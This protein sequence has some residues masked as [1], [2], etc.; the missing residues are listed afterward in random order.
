MEN[1]DS[2]IKISSWRLLVSLAI[3]IGLVFLVAT[4]SGRAEELWSTIV[5]AKWRWFLVAFLLQVATYVCDGSKW[6]ISIKYAGFNLKIRSLAKMAVEQLS[7]NQF[8]PSVGM[9]G[10]AI[11]ATEM[12][13]LG[14]PLRVVIRAIAIDIISLLSSYAVITVITL[15]FI[16]LSGLGNFYLM[17]ILVAFFLFISLCTV[18]FWQFLH[19]HREWKFLNFVRRFKAVSKVLDMMSQI[20]QEEIIP[21]QL[22]LNSTILRLIIFIL[23]GLTLYVLMLSIGHPAGLL[24]T[25]I[26]H[27]AGSIGGVMSFLPGGIGGFEAACTLILVL[28]GVPIEAALAGTLLLRA[29]VLWLPLIP[30]LIFARREIFPP[31]LLSLLEVK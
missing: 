19:H 9:A 1:S 18:V 10:N 7:M 17:L 2:R 22:F 8:I 16:Q 14:L 23:D 13:N 21:T 28:G 5:G 24:L 15:V 11:V 6:H 27:A 20:P 3:L 12:I 25:F 30:G 26:A 4:Q 31:E 29:F